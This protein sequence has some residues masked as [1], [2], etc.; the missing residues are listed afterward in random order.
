MFV[1]LLDNVE[2]TGRV[3]DYSEADVLTCHHALPGEATITKV[4]LCAR[5]RRTGAM[6]GRAGRDCS[7]P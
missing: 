7:S 1:V 4:R 6:P 3:R 5:P 2:V